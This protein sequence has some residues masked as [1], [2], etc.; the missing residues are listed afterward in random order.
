[1]ANGYLKLWLESTPLGGSI[2]TPLSM[3]FASTTVNTIDN[4][5]FAQTWNWSTATTQTALTLNAN[6]LTTGSA[7]AVSSASTGLTGNLAS[8][9]A[10]GAGAGVTGNVLSLSMAGAANTGNT[11]V[12]SNS[13][14]AGLALLVSAGGIR[15]GDVTNNLSLGATSHEPLLAGTAR[16]TKVAVLTAEYAGAVIDP[17]SGSNNVGSLTAAYSTTAGFLEGYYNWTTTVAA[18]AQTY[19]VAVSFPVPTDWSA[20]TTTTPIT[21]D[22]YS[23][24]FGTGLISGYITDTAGVAETAWSAAYNCSL[25]PASSS[26]WTTKTGCVLGG[27]YTANG[28]MKMHLR[29]TTTSA[30]TSV[31]LGTIKLSY[32][33]KY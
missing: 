16:H 11:L 33:S 13:S 8:I 20:W 28:V 10:T 30:V 32:F 4:L 25:T 7:L 14:S 18:P 2:N 27:T 31:R 22:T 19:D 23:S 6:G 26:A 5:N 15:L 21:V 3:L 12:V 9:T 29:L 17:A 24:T 1:M